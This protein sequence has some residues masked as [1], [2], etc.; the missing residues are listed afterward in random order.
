M[1]ILII[2]SGGREHAMAW[3]VA[4]S[5]RVSEIF[6]APGNAGTSQLRN[7]QNASIAQ[8]DHEALVK[9]VIDTEIDLTLV[10]PETPLAEGLADRFRAANKLVFGP[11]QAA[12]QIEA[13]KAFAKEFMQRRNIPTARFAVFTEFKSALKHLLSI[14]YSI[15]IKASGL[16]AGKGV[17][18]PDC[19]DDAEAALRQ[20]MLDREFGQAGDEVV[21]E[22]K[23]I[24]EEVSLLAFTDGITIKAM[25][26]A[27]DHKRLLDDDHGP[28]TG[29]MGA[30]APA[31]ICP[32]ALV[33]EFTRSILQ[34]T[35]DG[36][37][38]E[39][40]LFSGVIYAGLMLTADGPRLLEYNC[41]FG[42]PETQVILPLLE[43]D[44]VDIAE[45]CATQQ[46]DKIDIRWKQQ[47]AAC[48]VL[49]SK[50]YPNKYPIDREIV[51]L[52][53]SIENALI[54]HAGT[55]MIDNKIVTAG[56]RVLNA[57]GLGSN[58]R[59]ALKNAYA[60]IERV[61]FEGM[62]YRKDIGH[63]ALNG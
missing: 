48:V 59:A 26:P 34:P 25:P 12:A 31:P 16:A 56:G 44:L 18:I 5:P 42:D 61:T 51:R 30:Y 54:F 63:R 2:G 28:N 32:P 21:I 49:A 29:G 36:L 15:V 57:V 43:T 62:Q 13:S 27:Q 10:G 41:R 55:K 35:I 4:Q 3:K 7:T 23:L 6:V 39:N 46:L 9:F 47:S 38:A 37:R 22:E 33:A 8:D 1:K 52:D 17:I 60:L 19:A 50:G 20:T 14:D 11:S 40:R 58:L 45:A 24:G 53:Q